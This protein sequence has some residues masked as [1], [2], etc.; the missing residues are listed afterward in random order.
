VAWLKKTF[1]NPI[2]IFESKSRSK[3]AGNR[4]KENKNFAL[5]FIKKAGL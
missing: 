4:K 5:N 2:P 1:K 3:N